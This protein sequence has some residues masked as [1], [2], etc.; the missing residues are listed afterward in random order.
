MANNNKTLVNLPFVWVLVPQTTSNSATLTL[1]VS[2]QVCVAGFNFAPNVTAL[3][4]QANMARAVGSPQAATLLQR[5]L[6]V[7]GLQALNLSYPVLDY[8]VVVTYDVF[9]MTQFLESRLNSYVVNDGAAFLA[10]S[11]LYMV[12]STLGDND[13]AVMLYLPAFFA[14]PLPA[15][16]VQLQLQYPRQVAFLADLYAQLQSLRSSTNLTA[17]ASPGGGAFFELQRSVNGE[18]QYVQYSVLQTQASFQWILVMYSPVS[19]YSGTLHHNIV[20]SGVVAAVVVV[21]SIV[22]T[23]L[24]TQLVHRP[25][26]TLVEAMQHLVDLHKR[27]AAPSSPSSLLPSGGR[28][29][30]LLLLLKGGAPSSPTKP[31]A[32]GA[33]EAA[34]PAASPG[35]SVELQ[36]SPPADT[37]YRSASPP[38]PFTGLDG[39]G[40][41]VAASYVFDAGGA[42][43]AAEEAGGAEEVRDASPSPG[44]SPQREATAALLQDYEAEHGS[45]TSPL[46]ADAPTLQPLPPIVTAADRDRQLS[47]EGGRREVRLSGDVLIIPPAEQSTHSSLSSH[48]P[49]STVLSPPSDI[50]R[51]PSRSATSNS[52]S[53]EHDL[54][55]FELDCLLSKWQDTMQSQGLQPPREWQARPEMRM[56]WEAQRSKAE[57]KRVRRREASR[58][59]S[60]VHGAADAGPAG[61]HSGAA[62]TAQHGAFS[63][64]DC[65]GLHSSSAE[66]EARPERLAVDGVGGP[67]PSAVLDVYNSPAVDVDTALGSPVGGSGPRPTQQQLLL[68]WLR[69]VGSFTEVVQLETVPTHRHSP[70]TEPHHSAYQAS[71]HAL[72][73]VPGC[74]CAQ[75]FGWLL[76]RLRNS[77]LKLEK[78]NHAKE[79]FLRFVFHEVRVPL[80]ALGLGVEQLG[81]TLQSEREELLQAPTSHR[82]PSELPVDPSRFASSQLLGVIKDQVATIA[83]ILNESPPTHPH[84]RSASHRGFDPLRLGADCSLLRCAVL[85][86][87]VC[88][89]L[90]FQRIEENALALEMQEFSISEM[91]SNVL[92]SFQSEFSAKRLNVVVDYLRAGSDVAEVQG[93]G[94]SAGV[95]SQGAGGGWDAEVE[96]KVVGDQYRLRQVV[97]NFISNGQPSV[98]TAGH[99]GLHA[100]APLTRCLHSPLLRCCQP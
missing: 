20:V 12:A 92:H 98:S 28:L 83:R 62:P 56:A 43:A 13:L 50:S 100:A 10:T 36:S 44:R 88:S 30:A 93:G 64:A 22:V 90:S 2:L 72:S 3:V 59:Q 91:V 85:C 82:R 6:M 9:A 42:A 67:P 48:P 7:Q 84:T 19:D 11:D 65:C 26:V 58:P 52:D 35:G 63:L 49:P 8:V 23:M 69:G 41:T 79:Q 5:A 71:A 15:S 24:M 31:S 96:W 46:H 86:V 70:R 38:P 21:V 76:V 25:I 34:K 37:R 77:Q 99:G 81:D 57:R 53:S 27:P 51:E 66:P 75:T 78:A 40:F 29:A 16:T 17:D 45:S 47:G 18:S 74:A 54:T 97:A 95:A 55:S 80:N 60:A 1:S 68:S 4:A 89:V 73:P 94:L 32:A 87:C 14:S 33:S 39:G 61:A